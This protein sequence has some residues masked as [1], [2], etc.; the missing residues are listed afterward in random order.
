VTGFLTNLTSGGESIE[1]TD[2]EISSIVD[3]WLFVRAIE[4]GGE[5]KPRPVRSEV[6]RHGAFQPASR[7]SSDSA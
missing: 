7:I 2:V 6:A 4:L 5:R 3:T 1:K